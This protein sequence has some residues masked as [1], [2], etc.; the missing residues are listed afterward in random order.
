MLTHNTSSLSVRRGFALVANEDIDVRKNLFQLHL[1][2]L[3]NER[4]R[5]IQH[6]RLASRRSGLGDVQGAL[7]TVSQKVTLDVEE[8]GVREEL[9]DLGGV[10]V[11]G[12]KH[13]GGAE[14][15]AQGSVVV[16]ADDGAG[17][18]TSRRGLGLVRRLDTFGVV[19][20]LESSLQVVV[21]DRT[22]V[23]DRAFGKHVGG[24]TSG[25][26]GGTSGNVVNLGVGDDVVV[27][28]IS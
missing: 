17:T 4:S 13:L 9:A 15:G 19:G 28:I 16:G 25:V 3:G 26:L 7:E 27:A 20:L 1:E 18:G 8:L 5:E 2:E 14:G 24:S 12:R 22:D 11:R 21:T 23:R 6:D 10:E